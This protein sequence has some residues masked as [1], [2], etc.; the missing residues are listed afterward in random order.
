MENMTI[1]SHSNVLC[2][3]TVEGEKK[4]PSVRKGEK[5]KQQ[6]IKNQV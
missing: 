2:E 3:G 6:R 1:A 5:Y 4:L